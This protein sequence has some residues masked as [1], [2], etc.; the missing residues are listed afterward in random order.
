VSVAGTYIVTPEFTGGDTNQFSTLV[1]AVISMVT[2]H[3]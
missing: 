2:L 3:E 1:N